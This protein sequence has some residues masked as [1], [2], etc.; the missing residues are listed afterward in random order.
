MIHFVT[1][2][3]HFVPEGELAR[4]SSDGSLFVV[5]TLFTIDVYSTVRCY[6]E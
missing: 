5:Q 1:A 6:L 2:V 3:H 4:W